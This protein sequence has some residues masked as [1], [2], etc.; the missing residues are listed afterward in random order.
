MSIIDWFNKK[1]KEKE[2]SSRL[3]IPG[4]LWVKCFNCGEI[5]FLKE[6]TSN[7][8][9]C[10]K[11]NYHFR[12]TVEERISMLFDSFTE[13]HPEIS[14]VDFLGFTDTEPY[15]TRIQKAKKKTGHNDAIIVGT[16]KI[17]EKQLNVGIMDFAFMGG[18][19]GSVVG[20]KVVLL[21]EDA[22]QNRFPVIIFSSSGGARM[23][24]GL[25][26]LMQMAKTSG[27][28]YKLSEAKIPFISVLC[29]PTTGGTTASFAMLGDIN[30]A[31]PGAL[32]GFAG[33][34]VIEQTIRQK[35]P[36][37]FQRAEFLQDHGMIDCVIHRND[38][39]QKLAL[40]VSILSPS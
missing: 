24:E 19:M 30:I 39:K 36:K 18:S 23:Q 4:E 2:Q 37:G 38:L 29:D 16:A 35:L 5:L 12:I 25:T 15:Q 13:T 11:C 31:E 28:L 20:E 40:L 26:S 21:I 27:A 34:R 9:V 14:P 22:L 10:T 33:Q 17:A 8:K 3:N 6:L 1:E 7:N 32:I